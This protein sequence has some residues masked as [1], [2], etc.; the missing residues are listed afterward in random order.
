MHVYILYLAENFYGIKE[1]KLLTAVGLDIY[2]ADVETIMREAET[3]VKDV[4]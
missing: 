4:L 2:G 3:R 1:V